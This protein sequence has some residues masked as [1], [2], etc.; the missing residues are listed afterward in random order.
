VVFTDTFE[1]GDSKFK[2]DQ[3]FVDYRSRWD[4]VI[5][6]RS[7]TQVGW[8]FG[9]FCCRNFTPLV[10]IRDNISENK[11]GALM[12]A[13]HLRGVKSA[14]ICPYTPQQDQ[15]ENYLGRVTT[16]ASYAMVFSGAPLFFWRWAILC[17]VFIANI[18]ATYYSRESIWSTPYTLLFGEPFPNASI[19]VPF[20]CGAL[21]L[22]DKDDRAK[23][24]TRCVLLSFIHYTTSH[25]LYTYAFYSPRSKRVLYRQDAIFLVDTF[26]MRHAR[27]SIGLPRDGET[28]TAFRS[29]LAS[30]LDPNH[31]L[32]FREWKTGDS[33]PAFD[34]H[35]TGI[36]LHDDLHASR[37]DTPDFPLDW[38]RRFPH[39]PA[40]GP[41]SFHG[42]RSCPP[43]FSSIWI[44]LTFLSSTP[45]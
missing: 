4:D 2:Y 13:C 10:L 11:G 18:L 42:P 28:L 33:L 15:A 6:L 37:T 31:D 32:S 43:S 22:L 14:Y 1:T 12:D 35:A 36:A 44:L 26:P 25:P 27:A 3:A 16:M 20:G 21:V 17:A 9:E 5:P 34:D 45:G 40:F 24:K 29:P 8:A 19:V 23:F 38:P 41:C 30:A 39:H 7:R